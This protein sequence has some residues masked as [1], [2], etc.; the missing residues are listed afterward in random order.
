MKNL[1][2]V[3]FILAVFAFSITS[4][5]KVDDPQAVTVME[6]PGMATI[7]G[8]VYAPVN[9]TTSADTYA[10]SGTEL[11]VRVDPDDFPNV[12]VLNN[13]S[14]YMYYPVTVGANGTY[15]IDVPAPKTAASVRI[16]PQDFRANYIDGAGDTENAEFYYSGAYLTVSVFEGATVIQ[17]FSY[18]RN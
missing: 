6:N 2:V 4:C 7:S 14:E 12:S 15:S 18:A 17:D 13:G 8:I 5:K 16:Y 11:I 3:T 10:P 1:A 9:D